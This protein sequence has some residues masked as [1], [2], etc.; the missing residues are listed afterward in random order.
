MPGVGGRGKEP[1]RRMSGSP[2]ATGSVFASSPPPPPLPPP[3]HTVHR[4][5]CL[6][7]QIV[8]TPAKLVL[9]KLPGNCTYKHWSPATWTGKTC[10]IS[11]SVGVSSEVVVGAKPYSI[12]LPSL[13]S[14]NDGSPSP[15]PSGS[16]PPPAQSPPPA[17]PPPANPPPYSVG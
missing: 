10:A 14:K 13:F 3:T 15:P 17:S 5:S 7:L 1:P 8:C 4:R 9:N 11:G 6:R 12:P 16:N 2:R